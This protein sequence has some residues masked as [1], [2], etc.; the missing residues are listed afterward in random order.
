M[1]ALAFIILAQA[2]P[3]VTCLPVAHMTA[4]LAESHGEAMI[5][6]GFDGSA[7]VSV[8]ASPK[9][10]WT[11]TQT[12]AEGVSCIATFGEAWSAAPVVAEGSAL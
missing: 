5:G 10:S 2:T 4:W 11:I 8:Y 1:N 6:A 9:G 7:I 12:D 3:T